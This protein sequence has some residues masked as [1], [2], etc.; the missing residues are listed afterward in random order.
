MK[1][2]EL[3]INVPEERVITLQLP[4]DVSPGDHRVVVVIDEANTDMPGRPLFRTKGM[5]AGTHSITREEIDQARKDMW[6]KFSE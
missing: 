1:T 4:P 5:L 3:N 6:R 2:L